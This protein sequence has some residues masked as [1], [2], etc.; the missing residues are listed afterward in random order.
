MKSRPRSTRMPTTPAE[1][2]ALMNSGS[3]ITE[4]MVQNAGVQLGRMRGWYVSITYLGSEGGGAIFST[5]GMPDT[6][7]AKNGLSLW[8]EY[9]RPGGKL[10]A[11][12]V[13][14]IPRMRAAG[15]LV[16]VIDSLSG[17]ERILD[18]IEKSGNPDVHLARQ[19]I[20]PTEGTE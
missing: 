19:R 2:R 3:V 12:Q 17:T 13:L 1:A 9:K 14:N 6:F 5:A 20:F 11:S 18:T 16:F 7:W 15:V 10:R 8:I 4:A